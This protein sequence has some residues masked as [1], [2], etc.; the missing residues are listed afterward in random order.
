MLRKTLSFVL[1]LALALSLVGCGGAAS[2]STPASISTTS[3]NSASGNMFDF[4][5]EGYMEHF[6]NV[7]VEL[8][9]VSQN[10][11]LAKFSS[12]MAAEQIPDIIYGG[13]PVEYIEGGKVQE[14]SEFV[15]TSALDQDCT[16]EESV[17]DGS[18]DA[19]R[20]MGGLWSVPQNP[21]L[22]FMRKV[23]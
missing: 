7:T 22:P 11:F 17:I 2:S 19:C 20:S 21:G 16:V 15:K 4:L 8:E 9:V 5:V 6:P 14:L 23:I 1:V 18:L 12:L 13:A 3:T 10:D